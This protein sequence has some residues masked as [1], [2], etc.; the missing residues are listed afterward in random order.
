MKR[1]E[2]RFYLFR[3]AQVQV[4]NKTSLKSALFNALISLN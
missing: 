4:L 3:K 2:A 1:A